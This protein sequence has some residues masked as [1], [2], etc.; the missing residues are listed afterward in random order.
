[1]P[2]IT[3]ARIACIISKPLA[4]SYVAIYVAATLCAWAVGA[5]A[6][7]ETIVNFAAVHL[8]T[9]F[10]LLLLLAIA[11]FI[12]VLADSLKLGVNLGSLPEANPLLGTMALKKF[13][14]GLS[15]RLQELGSAKR[16]AILIPAAPTAPF[17][18]SRAIQPPRLATGWS[19]STHPSI[20]YG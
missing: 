9:Q 7:V 13:L 17:L 8:Q 19:P 20:T 1:M 6:L 10:P 16:S 5:D 4:I 3:A 11:W 12:C 2:H 15:E 14:L 18:T